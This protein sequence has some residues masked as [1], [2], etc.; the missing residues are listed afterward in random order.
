MKKMQCAALLLLLLGS[1]PSWSESLYREES[2]QPLVGDRR[3]YRVGDSITILVYENSSATTTADTSTAKSGALGMGIKLPNITDKTPSINAN[4]DFQGKGTIQRSGRLLAQITVAV[5]EIEKNGE[6]KIKGQQLIEINGDKQLIQI[7]GRVR[8]RDISE[9]NT[10]PS[11]RVAEARISY[12]GNGVLSEKQKP[13]ILSRLF[14]MLGF[15]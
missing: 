1:T 11:S 10:V 13:G 12:V 8:P 3:A 6:F 5:Q 2:Y 9:T 7:E 4:E 14:T 15:L